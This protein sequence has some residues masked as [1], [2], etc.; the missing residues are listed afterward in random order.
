MMLKRLGIDLILISLV[1]LPVT[2]ACSNSKSAIASD[3]ARQ[4]MCS[5][6]C[7]MVLATCDCEL[8]DGAT[9]MKA[10]IKQK[11]A[12][13]QSEE[14]VIQFFVARYGEQVLVSLHTPETGRK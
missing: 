2:I 3:I 5:C 6:G 1:L 7:G 8:P 4:L 13:G 9:E 11:L 12:Q 14:Q 10:L